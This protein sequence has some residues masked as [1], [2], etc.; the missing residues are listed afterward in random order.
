M[1]AAASHDGTWRDAVL[2][3][4]TVTFTVVWW[5][6][7]HGRETWLPVFIVLLLLIAVSAYTRS[8]ADS[9]GLPNSSTA[10]SHEPFG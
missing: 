3:V 7:D 9:G 8:R 10:T 1:Q 6:L 5:D 2:F 4:C